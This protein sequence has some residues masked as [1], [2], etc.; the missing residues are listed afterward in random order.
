MHKILLAPMAALL[1]ALP[2]MAQN[3]DIDI[4]GD[5]MYSLAEIRA[6]L[7]DFSDDD[8]DRLDSNNDGLLDAD[9]IAAGEAEGLLPR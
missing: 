3:A 2:A 8:F 5:G 4:N 9:E 7:P 1:L 6:A